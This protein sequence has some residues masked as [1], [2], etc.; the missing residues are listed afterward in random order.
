MCNDKGAGLIGNG[1]R[2][3]DRGGNRHWQG[4]SKVLDLGNGYGSR[5][6]RQYSRVVETRYFCRVW[7]ADALEEFTDLIILHVGELFPLEFVRHKFR[8]DGRNILMCV[9]DSE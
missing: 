7:Q 5:H 9:N 4:N 3:R 2:W 1:R 6:K 8:D